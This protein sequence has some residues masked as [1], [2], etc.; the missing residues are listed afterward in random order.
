MKNNIIVRWFKSD[1]DEA[2][3][4]K[5]QKEKFD[6][7]MAKKQNQNIK[8]QI[9]MQM[10]KPKQIIQNPQNNNIPVNQ[11]RN[12]MMANQ[13]IPPN[14]PMNRNPM[15]NMGMMQN[16]MNMPNVPMNNFYQNPNFMMNQMMLQKQMGG[17]NP[18]MNMMNQPFPYQN[19]N[20]NFN[21]NQQKQMNMQEQNNNNFYEEKSTYGKFTCKFE[22][23]IPNDQ[24]FQVV[25]RLIGSKGCN[26][27]R[28][29]DSCKSGDQIGVKLRLRGRGSGY[30]EGPENKESDDPLHLCISAK[31]QEGLKKACGLVTELINKIYEEYKKYCN[32][33]GIVPLPKIANKIDGTNTFHNKNNMNHY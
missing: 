17:Q 33:I 19:Q 29:V 25:R 27:K 13:F 14:M 18:K 2:I 7:I 12:P 4:S 1:K 24:E 21:N 28:I 15:Q 22:I 26:M 10:N 16:G 23:L 3:L 6:F 30:K 8:N 9:G 20:M 5:E 31:N 32:K 11:M